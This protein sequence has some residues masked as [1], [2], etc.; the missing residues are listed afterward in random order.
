MKRLSTEITSAIYQEAQSA[1]RE[2]S[3]M[4][5]ASLAEA[6]RQRFLHENVAREDIE[7]ELLHQGQLMGVA[8]IFDREEQEPNGGADASVNFSSEVPL[9]RR[10]AS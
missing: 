10:L 4:N 6:I 1:F 3:V 7:R 2:K 9:L 8:M 5:V